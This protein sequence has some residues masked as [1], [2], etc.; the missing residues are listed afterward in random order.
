MSI[1]K[2]EDG[3]WLADVEPVKGK[4]FRRR[5]KTK[6][7]A[8]RFEAMVRE[9]LAQNPDWNL[10][11][12]DKRRLSELVARW[13]LLHGHALADGENRRKLLVQLVA[14]LGDPVAIAFSAHHYTEYRAQQL[15]SGANGKT[16][17]NRLGYLRAVFNELLQQGEIDYPNPLIRVKPLKLQERELTYLND[18]QIT[19]LF[20][21]IRARCKTP[22]VHMVALICLATG[23]RWSEA[24]GL[25]PQRV[26]NGAVTFVN[27]KSK[28]ARSI[29]I[30]AALEH[31]LNAHFT[32][33]GLFSNCLNSFDKTL[34][35]SGLV[36]PAGQ[37]SHVLRHTFASHFIMNG[38]N[39]LTLQ[40]IL[41]HTSLAMTM[42]YAH[43]S[44]DHLQDAVRLGPVTG[45]E[46]AMAASAL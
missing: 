40:K 8:V 25:V 13:A 3:R 16:L 38:G 26:R 22:H 31:Q 21:A 29:P 42:R 11:P 43:L 15:A 39:I 20:E 33:H 44:P 30:S 18:E 37:S 41:G 46:I 2:Q 27:T 23:S 12:K 10:K 14:D 7:E 19:T 9:R 4:R 1:E 36:L 28:R 45:V 6:A 5:F 34:K 35:A 32:A 17:N 24:Q